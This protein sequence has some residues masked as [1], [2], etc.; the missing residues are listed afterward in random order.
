MART[1][2]E[3]LADGLRWGLYF[4]VLYGGFAAASLAVRGPG[5]FR[6]AGIPVLGLFA[7]YLIGGLSSGAVFGLL[8]RHV[9]SLAA[10]AAVGFVVALPAGGAMSVLVVPAAEWPGELVFV[11]VSGALLLG[12]VCGAYIYQ[13]TRGSPWRVR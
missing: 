9:S 5:A 8:R 10:A 7:A 6:S 2:R 12:P 1:L 3:D 13:R 11:T 4:A